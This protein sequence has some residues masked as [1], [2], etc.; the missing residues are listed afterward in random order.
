VLSPFGLTVPVT[1]AELLVKLSAGPVVALGALAA[2]ARAASWPT[3]H[4]LKRAAIASKL[5]FPR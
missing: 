3:T 2:I 5:S 1:F 4:K